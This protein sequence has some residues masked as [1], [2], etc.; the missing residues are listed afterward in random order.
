MGNFRWH[1]GF[2]KVAKQ[3]ERNV[4]HGDEQRRYSYRELLRCSEFPY[5]SPDHSSFFNHWLRSRIIAFGAV[6]DRRS[7]DRSIALFMTMEQSGFQ[8]SMAIEWSF[9]FD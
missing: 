7:G 8:G 4:L 9:H 2:L 1:K 6:Y 5:S 3:R